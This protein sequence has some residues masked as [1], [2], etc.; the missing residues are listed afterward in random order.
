MKQIEQKKAQTKSLFL[1]GIITAVILASMNV[2]LV[3]RIFSVQSSESEMINLAGRQR[4]VSQKIVKEVYNPNKDEGSLAK[5]KKEVENWSKIHNNFQTHNTHSSTSNEVVAGL[6]V[7]ITPYQNAI[8]NAILSAETLEELSKSDEIIKENEEQFLPLMDEIVEVLK[9]KSSS[10]IQFLILLEIL[11]IIAS[12]LVIVGEFVFIFK[13]RINRLHTKNEEL[14]TTIHG[15]S[16]SK[17]QLFEAFQRFDLSMDAINAGIWEWFILDNTEWWSEKFYNLLGYSNNEITALYS[18]FINELVHPEDKETVLDAVDKHLQDRIPF[19]IEIRMK[20]KSGEYNWFESVGKASWDENGNPIRMVGSIINI[21]ER[22][23]SEDLLLDQNKKLE[24]IVS[25]FSETQKVAK[26]GV[27]DVDLA[28]MTSNWSDEVYR[29]HEVPKGKVIKVEEGINYYREDYRDAIQSAV[30]ESISKNTSWDLECVIV[31]EKGSDVWVRTIGYPKFNDG[32]LIGLRG[33]FMDIDDE[34]RKAIKLREATEKLEMSVVTGQ[35]GIWVW[36]LKSNLLEWNDQMYQIMGVGNSDFN[37]SY[38]DFAKRVHPDDLSKVELEVGNTLEGGS[39]FYTEFRIICSKG[40]IRYINGRGDVIRDEEGVP[41]RM[42][43]TNL[44][45]T[46]RMDMLEK[47]KTKQAQL[48]VFVEQAP[49]A[50][51]MFDTEMRYITVSNMWYSDYNIVGKNIIGKCHYDVFPEVKENPEWLAMHQRVLKGREITNLK[52]K[53][54]RDDGSVQWISWKLIPWY[55]EPGSI[56]GL[57]MYTAD[58]T[59]QIEYQ[60]KLKNLNEILEEKVE[61][62]TQALNT[63]ILELESFSYSISHDLRAPLRSVN[64]FADILKEDYGNELDE[65]ANRLLDIIK[66]SGL[67]MGELIDDILAFSRLGRKELSKSNI[68]MTKLFTEVKDEVSNEYKDHKSEVEIDSLQNISGD[69]ALIRQVIVN[70]LSNAFKYST[71]SEIIKIKVSS[72]V[73]GGRVIFSVSDNGAGFDMKYHEK[74]FGV[75]QRLHSNSQFEGTGVGLAIVK[76]IVE[77][78]DGEIWAESVIGNGS[79]FYFSLPKTS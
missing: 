19:K 48:R 14:K 7:E 34:K 27:W 2:Y 73:K 61:E 54:V 21:S 66:N 8:S 43:G 55:D 9:D 41:I 79:T 26:I 63:A 76:R 57:I 29:I 18:T 72:E 58:I 70:L 16:E 12:A 4:M 37:G 40:E 78:H 68:G 65:E 30:D 45:I 31:T 39:A 38:E 17:K 53:F 32:E 28:T 23:H 75:F 50:V 33:L 69:N 64:G 49:V 15:V 10:R 56:G 77:K 35:V 42:I 59:D 47:L 67:K 1:I 22:K 60:E 71:E 13:P 44:D 3:Q 25:S 24:D 52:D 74:L 20:L 11:L 46:E 36:D 51:A 5:L 6:F 62:R